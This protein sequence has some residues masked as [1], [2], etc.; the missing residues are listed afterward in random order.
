MKLILLKK[1]KLTESENKIPNV[2]SLATKTALIAVGN[3]IP[4]V[5]TLVRKTNYST[6]FGDLEK[7]LTDYSHKKYITIPEFNT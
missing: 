3:K 1:A 4:D 7:K 2:S 5:S 6:K